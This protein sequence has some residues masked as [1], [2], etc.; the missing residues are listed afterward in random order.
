MTALSR[1][2]EINVNVAYL[3]GRSPNG[4]VDFVEFRNPPD[5]MDTPITLLYRSVMS[6]LSWFQIFDI[7]VDL[8]T[9]I[10]FSRWNKDADV[11]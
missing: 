9:M 5:S 3:D 2:L 6:Q 11:L 8:G 7:A 4:Q 10:S 1:A